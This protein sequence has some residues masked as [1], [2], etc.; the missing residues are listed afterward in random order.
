NMKNIYKLITLLL[1]SFVVIAG[2]NKKTQT[3]SDDYE[4]SDITFPLEEKVSLKIM[5]SS[6]PLAP[7]DPNDKLI[8][9]RLEEKT[10]VHI[11]WQ[12]LVVVTYGER[13]NRAMATGDMHDARLRAGFSV[14]VLSKY[15]D[16]AAMIPLNVLTEDN[17]PFLK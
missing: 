7:D 4:L 11:E 9:Q 16:E 5:T 2:C 17:V 12:N 14:Y 3:W 10:G 8:F 13:S 1:V 6:S 15:G